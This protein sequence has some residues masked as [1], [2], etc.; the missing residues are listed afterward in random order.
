[1]DYLI[2][3]TLHVVSATFLVGTG[4]GS[5]YYLWRAH[6]R[7][8]PHVLASVAGLVVQADWIFTLPTAILQ[9]LSGAWLVHQAGY[10]WGGWVG[11][12]L[13]LYVL[14]GMCW[15]PAVWLQMRIRDSAATSARSGRPLS[16]QNRRYAQIWFWL[17]VP[18][19]TAMV[20]VYALMVIKPL[21]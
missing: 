6:R 12:S 7:G 2:V 16:E 3:K 4:A 9:L 10:S 11:A 17:G 5:A 14:A 15:V 8:D 20:C 1:M 21:W 19:L 18:A 13:V